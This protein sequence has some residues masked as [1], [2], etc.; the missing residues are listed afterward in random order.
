MLPVSHVEDE[1]L[2]S[3]N[4]GVVLGEEAGD[5]SFKYTCSVPLVW[6][7]VLPPLAW[8]PGCPDPDNTFMICWV[9]ERQLPSCAGRA[10]ELRGVITSTSSPF[11]HLP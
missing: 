10:K 6:H 5:V 3:C 11:Y 1:D 9:R 7:I 4:L 2:A 8:F